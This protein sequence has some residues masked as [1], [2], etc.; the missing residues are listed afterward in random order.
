MKNVTRFVGYHG[1]IF[2]RGFVKTLYG[3]LAAG[4]AVMAVNGFGA[5]SSEDG[6]IAV[7]DFIGAVATMCVAI[8]C[9][10]AFGCSKKK[11]GRFSCNG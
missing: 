2:L 9:M 3:A 6:Y 8:S 7:C 5:V 1:K 4:L 11:N 10:Y